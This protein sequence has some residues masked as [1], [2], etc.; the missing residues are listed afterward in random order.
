MIMTKK[1]RHGSSILKEIIY[2][3]IKISLG[4]LILLNEGCASKKNDLANVYKVYSETAKI[5]PVFIPLSPG[6][7]TP[8]GWIK[9]WAEDAA[10][11]LTGHLDEY[12]PTFAEAWKGHGFEANGALPDGTG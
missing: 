7:V 2:A 5:K 3:T 1:L 10:K 4:I 12:D 6:T 11:G 9:D 8:T